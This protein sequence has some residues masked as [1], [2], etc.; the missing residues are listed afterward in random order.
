MLEAISTSSHI[1]GFEIAPDDE[2]KPTTGTG[3]TGVAVAKVAK[4]RKDVPELDTDRLTVEVKPE[5]FKIKLV[6]AYKDSKLA[7]TELADAHFGVPHGTKELGFNTTYAVNVTTQFRAVM[8]RFLTGYWRQVEYNMG[9]L[10]MML[11]IGLIFGFVYFQVDDDDVAGVQSKYSSA[12]MAACFPSTMHLQTGAPVVMRARAVYYRERAS[13]YYSSFVYSTALALVEI[14]YVV[15]SSIIFSLPFYFMAGYEAEAGTFLLFL[16]GH[17]LIS[18]A[19]CYLGQALSTLMPSDQ[20]V[21]I[22]VGFAVSM[23]F[24]FGGVFIPGP[25]IPEGW[26]W[27]FYLDPFP[28][29]VEALAMPQFECSGADCPTVDVITASGT[30]TMV[31]S[32]YMEDYTGWDH[33]NEVPSMLWLL[34][35]IAVFHGATALA[36]RYLKHLER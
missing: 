20:L 30:T 18:L 29:A 26:K 8:G 5:D 13:N 11:V 15:C 17:I 27:L 9:R 24:L 3:T 2:S 33:G 32:E 31:T 28:R 6:A 35:H 22:T 34:V 7:L 10:M 19:M 23:F 4:P 16:L 14:P 21:Q 36:L 12:F 1:D 25:S